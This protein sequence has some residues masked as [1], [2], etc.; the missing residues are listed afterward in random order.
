M[1]KVSMQRVTETGDQQRTPGGYHQRTPFWNRSVCIDAKSLYS[2]SVAKRRMVA[3]SHNEL[4][5]PDFLAARDCQES[6]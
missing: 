5:V 1:N 3:A 4:S 6:A 2:L